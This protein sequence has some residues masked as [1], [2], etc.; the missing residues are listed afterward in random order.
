[1]Q[2]PA[3]AENGR[4]RRI[5]FQDRF[6]IGI[7]GGSDA[8]PSGGPESRDA[9]RLESLAFGQIEKAHIPGIG[10]GPP[11][12]DVVD[13]HFIQPHGDLDFL[14]RREGDVFSLGAV[15]QGGIVDKDR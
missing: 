6:Q 3:F 9:G 2:G 15:S 10:S 8:G 5:A 1:M 12:L 7:V 4:G 11:A 13:P 14:I